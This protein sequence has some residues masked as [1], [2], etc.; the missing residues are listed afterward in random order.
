MT[1]DTDKKKADA[2]LAASSRDVA[3]QEARD[4]QAKGN[5]AARSREEQQSDPTDRPKTADEHILEQHKRVDEENKR[6]NENN[7]PIVAKELEEDER[8]H[9]EGK[10]RAEGHAPPTGKQRDVNTP[11]IDPATG[12]RHY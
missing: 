2:S 11:W 4:A 8:K 6:R 5:L 9:K 7:A 1:D 3:S 10:E 12:A